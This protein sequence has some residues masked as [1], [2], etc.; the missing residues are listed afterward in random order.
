VC[1]KPVG[2]R[3]ISCESDSTVYLKNDNDTLS[4]EHLNSFCAFDEFGSRRHLS[5]SNSNVT[6]PTSDPFNTKKD[7]RKVQKKKNSKFIFHFCFI[8]KY[9]Y[10]LHNKII[11]K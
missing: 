5:E 6:K 3:H 9:I 8:Y 1:E 4:N 11:K 10:T 7:N 2:I